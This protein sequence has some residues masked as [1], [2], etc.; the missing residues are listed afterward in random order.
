MSPAQKGDVMKWNFPLAEDELQEAT[1]RYMRFK[2]PFQLQGDVGDLV[3]QILDEEADKIAVR[4]GDDRALSALIGPALGKA[5]KT[6]QA[7]ERNCVL[8]FGE[9]AAVLVRTNVNLLINI[10]YIVTDEKPND[11]C[12]E[13]R[14]D[15]WVRH[16]K[17]IKQAYDQDVDPTDAPFPPDKLNDLA[18]RWSDVSIADRAKKVPPH[19]YKIGY[20]FYSSLEHSDARNEIGPKIE[21]GPRD[22][23]IEVVLVHN[24]DVMALILHLV[25]RYWGIERPDIFDRLAGLFTA[26]SQAPSDA[27]HSLDSTQSAG[28]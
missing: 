24:A 20:K 13:W 25:C 27:R 4:H 12:A 26:F 19:H 11:R 15:T 10:A 8:G 7:V 9:D 17:W 14:A 16:V 22:S 28:H 6:F 2:R 5:M 3:N 21:S 1:K 18:K 23:H